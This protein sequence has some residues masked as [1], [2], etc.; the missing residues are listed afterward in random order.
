MEKTDT[1]K[2][3][4]TIELSNSGDEV[5][6]S[7]LTKRQAQTMYKITEHNNDRTIGA[8]LIKMGWVLQH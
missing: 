8:D 7:N 1:D 4:F 2:Y 6:W 5:V 3:T